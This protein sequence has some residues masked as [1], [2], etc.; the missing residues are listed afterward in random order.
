MDP[1][2]N[3]FT[4]LLGVPTVTI[5]NIYQSYV[6]TD[7]NVIQLMKN[8]SNFIA[9]FEGYPEF[10]TM[11]THRSTLDANLTFKVNE[12]SQHTGALDFYDSLEVIT[13]VHAVI[14]SVKNEL[15]ESLK[16]WEPSMN[17]LIDIEVTEASL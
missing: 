9:V 10:L 13:N 5:E 1:V 11:L 2:D 4:Q 16:M 17:A 3:Q 15:Y 6:E 14:H 8:H 12:W 7:P